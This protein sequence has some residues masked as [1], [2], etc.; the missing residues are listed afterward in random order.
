MYFDSFISIMIEQL[1]Q[2]VDKKG[3]TPPPPPHFVG[4][5]GL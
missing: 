1:A 2:V 4:F 5:T 3:F